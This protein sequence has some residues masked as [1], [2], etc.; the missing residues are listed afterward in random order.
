MDKSRI[1]IL[2]VSTSDIGGGAE[3]V[4]WDL[5]QSYKELGYQSTLAVGTKRSND[6]KCFLHP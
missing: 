5:F 4:A 6:P 3:K 2:Q 1:N